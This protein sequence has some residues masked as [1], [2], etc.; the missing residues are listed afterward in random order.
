MP[1]ILHGS[2]VN[3]RRYLFASDAADAFDTIL[4]KG[5]IGEIYNVDSSD[6]ISNLDLAHKLLGHF[7]IPTEDQAQ[8]IQHVTDRPF[9]DMRYAVDARKL[10]SLGWTQKIGLEEGLQ[11]T[12]EWYKT[13]GKGW[14]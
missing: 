2:G 11:R 13:C 4:H 9:N 7:E 12:V 5:M 10:R 8:W 6:E 14:W 1:V 3:A